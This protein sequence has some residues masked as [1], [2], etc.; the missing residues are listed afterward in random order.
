MIP[1]NIITGFLGSGKT[2]FLKNLLKAN[3]NKKIAI[4]QNEFAPSG[5]DGKELKLLEPNIKLVEINNGSVFCMCQLSNFTETVTQL[6]QS[7]HLEEI[8]LETSGLADPINVAEVL[9]AGPLSQSVFLNKVFTI[10]DGNNFFKGLNMIERFRHQIMVAD[11]IIINK[12]DLIIDSPEPI[13]AEIKKINPYANHHL[14]T[15]CE[16]DPAI[17]SLNFVLDKNKLNGDLPE[18]G[19]RPKSINTAV[20]KTHKKISLDNLVCFI[21]SNQ[22]NYPRF[23]G[24][25]NLEHGS[26]IVFHS[27]FNDYNISDLPIYKGP[28]EIIAFGEKVTPKELKTRFESFANKN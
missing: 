14:T 4:I 5:V 11:E 16:L 21:K 1:F 6:T 25:I 22:Q 7:Y 28:S 27:V 13:I 10:V 12:T 19:G 20:I 9:T 15:F 24:I 23:K 3:R 18:A 2:T 17:F 8:Y 26:C